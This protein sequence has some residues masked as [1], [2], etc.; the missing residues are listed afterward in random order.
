MNRNRYSSHT[1]MSSKEFYDGFLSG[2]AK[3]RDS[4]HHKYAT[5]RSHFKDSGMKLKIV[6]VLLP[7]VLL[8]H[9]ISPM[10]QTVK[11]PSEFSLCTDPDDCSLKIPKI[12]HQTYKDEILPPE[13]KDAPSHWE[14]TH[15]GWEYMYWTDRRNRE[16]IEKEYPWFLPTFDAYPNGIQRADAIR[17][18]ILYHYGGVYADMDVD[19]LRSVEPMLANSE[20]MVSE[21]PNLG[22]TNA[23]MS[24]TKHS[25]FFRFVIDRLQRHSSPLLGRLSRHWAIMLSTGPTFIWLRHHEYLK[26]KRSNPNYVQVD[27]MPAWVW[28]Y[29]FVCAWLVRSCDVRRACK[30][31]QCITMYKVSNVLGIPRQ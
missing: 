13:W 24:S 28:G 4:K 22:L 11:A 14:R 29:V 20:A 18:F 12:I 30:V 15:P 25:D 26:T 8:L 10:L 5:L 2:N 23:F 7:C 21:T 3:S 16:F 6:S 27:R 9:R 31:A 1:I 17:Y 19:P